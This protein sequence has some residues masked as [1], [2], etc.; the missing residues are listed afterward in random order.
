[1][2]PPPLVVKAN[3]LRY[4]KPV[5]GAGAWA[6]GQGRVGWCVGGGRGVGLG[7]PRGA[8][9]SPGPGE[10]A[11][12]IGEL[13]GP[14][15]TK[16][17]LPLAAFPW[18]WGGGSAGRAPGPWPLTPAP[19]RALLV[20]RGHFL[21]RIPRAGRARAELESSLI[22]QS[23]VPS[24]PPR[25][26]PR[27][28]VLRRGTPAP[29]PPRSPGPGGR[30]EAA[31]AG[32]AE[33]LPGAGRPAGEG[34]GGQGAGG[35]APRP[36][37]AWTCWLHW[38]ARSRAW[39]L[40]PRPEPFRG[41]PRRRWGW[42]FSPPPSNFVFFFFLG[43]RRRQSNLRCPVLARHGVRGPA[44]TRPRGVNLLAPPDLLLRSEAA[45]PRRPRLHPAGS[46]ADRV[47]FL[48]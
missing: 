32:T 10:A 4:C 11:R 28:R 8:A 2:Q 29:P 34:T 45:G 39:S 16:R 40:P 20:P 47:A 43:G 48:P 31:G 35:P 37:G 36:A 12:S 23:P 9:L 27:G 15:K 41:S 5:R 1:M 33:R 21:P 7:D 18:G 17:S 42:L 38:S 13:A 19:L 6:E 25:R 22:L 3:L 24:P 30:R 46:P 26:Q 44:A 14:A